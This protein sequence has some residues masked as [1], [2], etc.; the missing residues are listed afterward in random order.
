MRFRERDVRPRKCDT[1]R[2]VGYVASVI[3]NVTD[4]M[5]GASALTNV[6]FNLV[7]MTSYFMTC[8]DV[9]YRVTLSVKVS[10]FFFFFCCSCRGELGKCQQCYLRQC[11]PKR[12]AIV[13]VLVILTFGLVFMPSSP[14]CDLFFSRIGGSQPVIDIDEISKSRR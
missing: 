1:R 11:L 3:V 7:S 13:A 5:R 2:L 6:T 12:L 9:R 14:C 10:S 4:I 8:D